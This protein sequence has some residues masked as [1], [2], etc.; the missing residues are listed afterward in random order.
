MEYPMAPD[1]EWPEAWLMPDTVEDQRK[2]TRTEPN[3]PVTADDLKKMGIAYWKMDAESFEYPVKS[4][5][6]DPKDAMDPKLKAIRDARGYSY[7]DI[8]TVHP[9]H[10]PD[11][12]KVRSVCTALLECANQ[13]NTRPLTHHATPILTQKIEAFFEEHI[14]DAEEIRYI[15]GGSGYFDVRNLEDKWVRVHVKKGDLMTLPEGIYHRFTCDEDRLTHV[16]RLFIGLPIWTPFNRPQEE[17]ESRQKY[18]GEFLSEEK[19]QEE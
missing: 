7:A 8:I 16:M 17:H 6:W 13:S 14:H 12:E 5:P 2:E 18:V 4:V 19:K 15:I 9:D 3:V 10:L 11:F 1:E